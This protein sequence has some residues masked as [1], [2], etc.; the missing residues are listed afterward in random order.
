MDEKNVA[1]D[2]AAGLWSLE[3]L[4]QMQILCDILH[5]CCLSSL[6]EFPWTRVG[7]T[8]P[9]TRVLAE[10]AEETEMVA[11]NFAGDSQAC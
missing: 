9:P 4:M 7:R 2:D 1:R 5:L 3:L 8:P 6:R 10:E 11:P